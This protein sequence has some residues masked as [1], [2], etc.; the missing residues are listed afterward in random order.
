[1]TTTLHFLND[2]IINQLFVIYTKHRI[3]QQCYINTISLHKNDSDQDIMH[4][5]YYQF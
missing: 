5:I 3:I 1:M 4:T 2:K